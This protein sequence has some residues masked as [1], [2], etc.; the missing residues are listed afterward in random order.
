MKLMNGLERAVDIF[1]STT[2]S[3]SP[4]ESLFS[5]A[6]GRILSGNQ[7]GIHKSREER[8]RPPLPLPGGPG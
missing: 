3:Q 7:E 5:P 8:G 4:C 6:E 2:S 1:S